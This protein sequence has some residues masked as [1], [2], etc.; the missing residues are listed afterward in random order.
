MLTPAAAARIE[1]LLQRLRQEFAELHE[2][3]RAAAQRRGTGL[4]PVL[5]EWE[6]KVFAALHR[7]D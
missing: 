1:A 7:A 5:G 6:P 4:L 3:S 2:Q